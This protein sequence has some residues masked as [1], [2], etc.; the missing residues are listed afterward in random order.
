MEGAKASHVLA[1][2][3]NNPFP[4]TKHNKEQPALHL[5]QH[6]QQLL[7]H[8]RHL[9]TLL[10]HTAEFVDFKMREVISLNGMCTRDF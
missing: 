5:L 7:L 6:Q 1:G 8:L 2:A 9:L 4:S 3:L 10:T